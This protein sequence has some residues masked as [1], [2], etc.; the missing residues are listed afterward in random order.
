MTA[1]NMIS[2]MNDKM[3]EVGSPLVFPVEPVAP[4][5]NGISFFFLCIVA[6]IS[7]LGLVGSLI[8]YRLDRKDI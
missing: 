5:F 8:M 1:A 4:E 6:S 3:I 7:L 2:F